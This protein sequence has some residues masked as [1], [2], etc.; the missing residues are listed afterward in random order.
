MTSPSSADLPDWSREAPHAL[1][2]PGRRL[3]PTICKY[4]ASGQRRGPVARLTKKFGR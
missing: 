2:G 3:E 4:Q 1:R